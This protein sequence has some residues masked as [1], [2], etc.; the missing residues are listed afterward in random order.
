[1]NV[2][3]EIMLEKKIELFSAIR[4]LPTDNE[5]CLLVKELAVEF[6]DADREYTQALKSQASN[7]L[8][9]WETSTGDLT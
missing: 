1:M 2:F 7:L 8:Q 4:A 9:E 3:H 5:Q 6:N